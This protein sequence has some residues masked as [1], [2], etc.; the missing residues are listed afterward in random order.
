MSKAMLAAAPGGP[1]VLVWTDVAVAAPGPGE[2]LVRQTAVGVNFIDTY[3]RSGLYAWPDS[4]II[5]G[6]EAAGVVEALG[7]GVSHLKVGDRVGYT[8]PLGAYCQARTLAADRLVRL[9]DGIADD[10]AATIMLKGLTVQYLVTSTFRVEPGMTVLVHAA[11]GGVGLLMG[12]WLNAIGAKAIG[13]AGSPEKVALA[14]AHG[15]QEV[16]DYRTEDFVARVTE[17]TGGKGCDVVYDSVGRDT[18]AGSLKCLRRRGMFVSFG[19][20]SGPIEGFALPL[21]AQGGSLSACRPM[22]FH[23]IEERAE[24]EA[25]AADLFGRITSGQIRAEVH[26]RFTLSDAAAAHRALESRGTIGATVLTV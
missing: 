2:A 20:S 7:S 10:V 3:F 21:L 25:R 16:I 5:V 17:I 26:Q 15:Y 18:W 24:L 8:T 6:A 9:P 19:Q 22:L 1:E 12:Q 13:T 11:A 14:K 23:Y 4:Q